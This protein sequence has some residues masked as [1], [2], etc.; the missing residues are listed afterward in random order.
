MLRL[1]T[2]GRLE[3]AVG[4]SPGSQSVP[5][6]PK[7]LALLAYL[8]I[9]ALGIGSRRD[10]L[11]GLFWPEAG[12]NEAR[13]ALRQ[14]LYHLRSHLGPDVLVTRDEETVELTPGRVW[15]DALELGRALEAR[16]PVA[17]LQLYRGDFL[18]GVFL[19]DV[20]PEFEQW[21]DR[22]RDRLRHCAV[23]AAGQA[24]DEAERSGRHDDAVL[25]A[26]RAC[27]L[28]PEDEPSLRRLINALDR[29]GDHGGALRVYDEFARRLR[30]EYDGEPSTETH[31]LMKKLRTRRSTT[32]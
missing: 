5:I 10:T 21:V 16:T 30:T 15:C 26:R 28:A 18:Q 29:T 27:E 23:T 6:Q 14:A 8:S 1:T 12:R 4:D 20:A 24:A 22:T 9:A 17:A 25:A 7:R 13:R 31:E 32:A 19:S 11:V 2:L 3:L